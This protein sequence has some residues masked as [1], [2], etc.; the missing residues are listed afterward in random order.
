MVQWT[1]HCWPT[2][3]NF[4][5]YS[6]TSFKLCVCKRTRKV[7][8]INVVS[9]CTGLQAT[10]AGKSSIRHVT[11]SPRGRCIK[12]L[13]GRD[14]GTARGENCAFVIWAP[15]Y[16]SRAP[17]TQATFSQRAW[18]AGLLPLRKIFF[19][20]KRSC[21]KLSGEYEPWVKKDV[22]PEPRNGDILS[23]CLFWF[24]PQL[25]NQQKEAGLARDSEWER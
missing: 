20:R 3:P 19:E 17:D 25:L 4:V 11:F 21:T 14:G 10:L 23:S 16:V 2:T 7:T 5:A 8:S 6:L 18:K 24:S 22:K 1:Q 12:I 13:G 15:I 9:V